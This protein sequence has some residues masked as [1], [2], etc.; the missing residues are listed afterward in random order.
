MEALDAAITE[1][2]FSRSHPQKKR[3]SQQ[4]HDKKFGLLIDIQAKV[5]EGKGAGYA[6]W[7]KVFNLKQMAQVMCFCRKTGLTASMS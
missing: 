2:K 6:R 5:T 3:A 1:K 4:R 7:A